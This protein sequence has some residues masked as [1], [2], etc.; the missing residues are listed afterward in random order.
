MQYCFTRRIAQPDYTSAVMYKKIST[1][2]SVVQSYQSELVSDGVLTR[3]YIAAT[4]NKMAEALE[5]YIP[6]VD[7]Y[8]VPELDRPRGWSNCTWPLP[9]QWQTEHVD[10]GVNVDILRE[11]GRRSVTVPDHI[12][13]D[14]HSHSYLPTYTVVSP[15]RS[16][17]SCVLR[18]T[19]E[20]P[21]SV[22]EDAHRQALGDD[23]KGSRDRFFDG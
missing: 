17:L 13:S 9:G 1:Q 15:F 19:I 20:N 8:V 7:S 10:T 14:S 3:E 16:H 6:L 18:R 21:S 5:S 2:P 22:A 23:C 4:K 11:V 12:V